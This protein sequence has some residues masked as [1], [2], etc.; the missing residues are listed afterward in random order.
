MAIGYTPGGSPIFFGGVRLTVKKNK[1]KRYKCSDDGCPHSTTKNQAKKNGGVCFF[2][3]A[4]LKG[5]VKPI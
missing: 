4:H 3:K 5:L 1:N 2:C